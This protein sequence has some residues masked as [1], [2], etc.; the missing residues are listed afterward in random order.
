MRTIVIQK[1]LPRALLLALSGTPIATRAQQG[2]GFGPPPN[3]G[4]PG[5][6]LEELILA[7]INFVLILV[8]V[9]ALAFLVYG[10][11]RYIT[12]RGEETE[13]GVAK[14][15]ITN[16]VIGIAVIGIAAAVVNFVVGAIIVG[17]R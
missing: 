9:L 13:V 4:L 11:F 16:A 2:E 8:G 3:P 1:N 17:A 14:Q 15:I 10:G 5:A 6:P 12:S 7:I